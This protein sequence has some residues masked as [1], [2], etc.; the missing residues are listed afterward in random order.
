MD[1]MLATRF[2]RNVNSI[3]RDRP[4][5][6]EELQHH[7]PSLF[8]E[9]AHSSR[10]ER[11]AYIPTI[12]VLDA[13]RKEGFMP[14]SAMQSRCLREDKTPYTKH[15]LRLRH[16][17]QLDHGQFKALKIGD[18][19]PEMLLLN[20]HDG[21][22]AYQMLS[23]MYRLICTNGMTVQDGAVRDVRVPHKGDVRDR[24]LQGAFEVLDGFTRV[25]EKVD[26]MRLITLDDTE[27]EILAE[28]ALSVRFDDPATPAP[29]TASQIN[30]ARR[31]EDRGNDLWRTFNRLQENAIKGAQQGRNAK[32]KP[33]QTRPVQGMDRD[34]GINRALWLLTERM[35]ALKA[36]E[37]VPGDV[38]AAAEPVAA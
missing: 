37:P 11:Y 25:I 26:D 19:V 34:V 23:G 7:V 30:T 6:T 27:Q 10:S 14:Y 13:L 20:S 33:M 31:W 28:A 24:V 4:L 8:A 12:A 21:T 3:R 5:T 18:S 35:R 32:G 29:V 15:M 1:H 16:T 17:S 36:G 22:S 2:G 9:S 38:P